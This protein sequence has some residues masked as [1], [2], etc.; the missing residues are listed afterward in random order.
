MSR[1][2]LL[3]AMGMYEDKLDNAIGKKPVLVGVPLKITADSITAIQ[4]GGHHLISLS[5]KRE[6]TFID[7][8]KLTSQVNYKLSSNLGAV[9]ISETEIADP[10][11]T[12]DSLVQNAFDLNIKLVGLDDCIGMTQPYQNKLITRQ[13]PTIQLNELDLGS[14]L[15]NND[16]EK[17]NQLNNRKSEGNVKAENSSRRNTNIDLFTTGTSI[18][19]M[20]FIYLFL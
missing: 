4:D 5:S 19:L 2:G 8:K 10:V 9:W 15:L 18:L 16:Q 6:I 17:N 20:G 13:A 3:G 7:D 11:K 12:V 14:K 1:D